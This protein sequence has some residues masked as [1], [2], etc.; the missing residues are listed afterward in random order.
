MNVNLL[1]NSNS[2]SINPNGG[3]PTQLEMLKTAKQFEAI[4]LMQL[5]S[6]LNGKESS[7]GD[8]D[9]LFG[10]DSGTDMA[11]KMFSEQLAT[12]ISEAGGFGL[13]NIILRQMGF[14][15]SNKNTEK[16][17][18]AD[19][20]SAVKEIKRDSDLRPSRELREN[21]EPI[22]INTGVSIKPLSNTFNGNPNST[23]VVS[24]FDE[25][26]V[27][28]DV[29]QVLQI[30]GKLVEQPAS[31][32][33]PDLNSSADVSVNKI[34]DA[35][36]P[37]ATT[38]LQMP[39]KGRISSGFGN[40]FHPIDKVTK[41]HSGI[42]IAAP[43]GTPIGAAAEG[44]VTFAG[45]QKGYGNLVV[46]KHADGKETRYGHME[47]IFVSEG[48]KVTV[49]Q[50][51]ASV[52]SIGKSTGPHLHFEVKEAGKMVDPRKYLSNVLQK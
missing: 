42:D 5:T 25:K 23:E 18:L 46:V 30:N 37:I 17:N 20:I 22:K 35:T 28:D 50:A 4:L 3:Q 1:D 8:E 39:V 31:Q 52:G 21:R 38:Q 7:E 2:F 43:R 10:G 6:I 32:F 15:Q 33:M 49:G 11:K 51:I 44:V 40:R 34:A 48:E 29:K 24:T 14:D 41:F 12:T 16:G 27:T 13:S 26:Y 9:P 45:S 47:K 19:A 36:M